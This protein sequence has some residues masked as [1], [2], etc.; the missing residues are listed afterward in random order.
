MT[1]E[2]AFLRFKSVPTEN[3]QT[4]RHL[5]TQI[6]NND[7]TFDEIQDLMSRY[8]CSLDQL[9]NRIVKDLRG[10]NTKRKG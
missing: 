9:I 8:G 1:G 10:T 6:C 2:L 5:V 4:C 7:C 3:L